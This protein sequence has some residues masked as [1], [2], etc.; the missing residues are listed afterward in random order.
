[1]IKVESP[2][3]D[4]TRTWSPP[5]TPDG[6]ATYFLA[7]NRNK[8]SIALDLDDPEDNRLAAELARRADVLIDNFKPGT[9]GALRAGPRGAA[10]REPE[11]RPLLDHRLRRRRRRRASR[12]RPVGPGAQRPHVDHWPEDGDPSAAPLVDVIA[13]PSRRRDP[14]RAD[15]PRAL[16]RG[17]ANRDRPPVQ[18]ALAALVNQGERPS[19]RRRD[20]APA[21]QRASQHRAVC[22]LLGRRRAADDLRRETTASSRRSPTCSG[23]GT[24]GQR[25]ETNPSRVEHREA[26]SEAIE[27]RIGRRP[28]RRVGREMEA[29]G[30]LAGRAQRHRRRFRARRVAGARAGGR[31]RC[32]A[33]LSR[34]SAC[35][36]RRRRRDAARRAWTSTATRSAASSAN[37]GRRR[38]ARDARLAETHGLEPIDGFGRGLVTPLL[39]KGGALDPALRGG[40]VDGLAGVVARYAYGRLHLGANVSFARSPSPSCSCRDSVRAPR[41]ADRRHPLRVR[42]PQHA[43]LTESD[44]LNGRTGDHE[45]VPRRELAAP[46]LCPDVRRLASRIPRPRTS[47]SSSRTARCSARSRRTIRERPAGRVVAGERRGRR[48]DPRESAE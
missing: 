6:A 17:A 44:A 31:A 33:Q 39:A 11:A 37:E 3:G 38:D 10:G 27:R 1:M 16:R 43:Y 42:D 7:V 9:L 47:P 26:F 25:R 19:Q 35:A 46:A 24:G 32:G 41:A 36:G 4:E 21:R 5:T 28:D 20:P 12:L 34:R 45:P 18:R 8:R 2:A 15:G 14:R 22:D 29:A 13:G 48:A 40:S 30:V 23:T